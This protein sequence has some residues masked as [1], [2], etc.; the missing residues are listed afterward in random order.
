MY[1]RG[2]V[3]LEQHSFVVGRTPLDFESLRATPSAT[4]PS[5]KSPTPQSFEPVKHN[6]TAAGCPFGVGAVLRIAPRRKRAISSLS[7]NGDLET[8]LV[9]SSEADSDPIEYHNF[10]LAGDMSTNPMLLCA[11][12][13]Q[14]SSLQL[15]TTLDS[16][17]PSFMSSA[18]CNGCPI[19][20]TVL[21][22]GENTKT[23][24]SQIP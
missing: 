6:A 11:Q 20:S 4:I 8:I 2:K 17:P 14:E 22:V 5:T 18:I 23:T 24:D 10:H 3:L 19:F 15:P 16:P 13:P 12:L 1:A 21:Y 9:N 7:G